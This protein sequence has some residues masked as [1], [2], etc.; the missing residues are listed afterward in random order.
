ME[1]D[2]VTD[3]LVVGY[4][5]AGGVA[6]LE[7]H[8]L[9]AEVLLIE[10]MP[11]GGGI[12]ICS[13]GGCRTAKSAASAFSYLRK[14]CNGT[15]PDR[16]L[17]AFADGMTRI[18]DWMAAYAATSGAK[19]L[20]VEYPGNYPFPG[21]EDLGFTMYGELPNFDQFSY[22][23]HA[24]G[25]RGGARHFKVIEDNIAARG[26]EVRLGC[27]ARRLL[28]DGQG[29]VAGLEAEEGGRVLRIGARKGVVLACGGFE[30]AEDLKAQ[31][32]PGPIMP[33][34]FRG[35]TGDGIRMAQ[36]VGAAL[37]HMWNVHGTYGFRHP[38][39][40][41]PFGLRLARLPD[42]N[43]ALERRH[44]MRMAWIVVD[45]DGQRYMDEFPPYMQDTGHR[46]MDFYDTGKGG[47]PRIPSYLLFDE[48]GRALYPMAIP[49]FNDT[50]ARAGWSADNLA[51]VE[52]G[53]LKRA[54]TI[55]GLARALGLPEAGLAA[56]VAAWNRS[57]KEG[58]DAAFGRIPESM[59]P[60]ATPPYY[61][62]P[63]WPIVSNTQGGPV[64]DEH[65]RVLDA[66]GAP[67]PG[68]Y[69]AG[70]LGG[71][72]GFLYLAGG[73]LAECYIGAKRATAHALGLEAST[74][75]AATR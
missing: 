36:K 22:Y 25:L 70:E 46:P 4:G 75:I 1:F 68:L 18:D 27:P 23:P 51:E 48:A 7:A 11:H 13:G 37:W 49:S 30:A 65:W 17:E 20:V 34:A 53:L 15:T 59:M 42:W 57:C 5:F 67:I 74:R 2:R 60:L 41:Y 26:I 32:L 35:S 39:P 63:V 72:F 44:D 69:E 24:R 29:R 33:A 12:S 56:S 47:Y 10:K 38:D 73:N 8:D 6:A 3:I 54:D 43:P 28:T 40:D 9:G 62:A 50:E 64:H 52:T 55:E 61:G 16:V 14:T 45:G 31:F 66:F 58:R 71:I 21:F 19:L